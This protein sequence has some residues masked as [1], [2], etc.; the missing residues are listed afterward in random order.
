MTTRQF[1]IMLRRYDP[2][3]VDE[4]I[5][6][7]DM[8]F[9]RIDRRPEDCILLCRTNKSNVSRYTVK[10]ILYEHWEFVDEIFTKVIEDEPIE[11]MSDEYGF[12]TAD[13]LCG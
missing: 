11:D 1:T 9:Y 5:A 2:A 3:I 13:K 7:L 4:M 6:L 10:T 8:V 12:V